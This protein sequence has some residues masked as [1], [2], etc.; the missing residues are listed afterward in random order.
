[1]KLIRIILLLLCFSPGWLYAYSGDSLLSAQVSAQ[2]KPK[3]VRNYIRPCLYLTFSSTGSRPMVL[4]A[5]APPPLSMLNSRLGNYQLAQSNIGFYTPLYTRT[6]FGTKDS[7]DVNTFHLLLTFNALTDRPGFSGL[8]QQHKLY[9]LGMGLRMFY[10]FG[11]RFIL[12]ADISPFA[13]GDK[14]DKLHTQQM[15]LGMSVAASYM[16]NPS[17]SFRV[18]LTRTFLWGNR[19]TLPMVGIRIGK[20]DGTFYFTAQFPRHIAFYYQPNRKINISLFSRVYGGVY[21][22]SNVDSIYMGSDKVIQFGHAGLANG[23][24]FEYRPG[25]NFSFF[26]SGGAVVR[27]KIW[28]YSNSF[29]PPHGLNRFGPFF[30]ALPENTL[31]LNFGLTWR[32]GKSKKSTGN[33][34]MYDIFDLN[35]TMD[36]G[37]N[38]NGPGNGNISPKYDK[39]EM[40]KVQYSDVGDLLDESDLY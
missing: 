23:L 27:N 36:P 12:F 24:R 4:K 38:N 13:T 35:N 10:G 32:F 14:Y 40:R 15:R 3:E 7:T 29:N 26:F 20:L 22:F 31:F 18:G 19:W 2:S 21:N 9:K 16:V 17:F 1:M 6:R 33:Y 34:L 39:K 11:S 25:P 30:T 28:F 8:A 5:N 37:D